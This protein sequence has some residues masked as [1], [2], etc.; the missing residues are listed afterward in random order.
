MIRFRHDSYY[1]T[2]WCDVIQ[3]FFHVDIYF[4]LYIR[5]SRL[6]KCDIDYL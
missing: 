3:Y 1:G 5:T 2:F 6:Y 4:L